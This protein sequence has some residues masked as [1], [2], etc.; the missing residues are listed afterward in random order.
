MQAIEQGVSYDRGACVVFGAHVFKVVHCWRD[1]AGLWYAELIPP[2][3]CYETPASLLPCWQLISL[4][5]YMKRKTKEIEN[6]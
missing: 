6:A 1:I 3:A 5:D 4:K 2:H